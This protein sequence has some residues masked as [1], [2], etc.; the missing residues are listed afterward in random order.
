MSLAGYFSTMARNNAWSNYRLL[1]ACAL[2]TQAE[3]EAR[4]TSFFPSLKQTLNHILTVDWYYLDALEGAG[5]GLA[6]FDD[7]TPC[8]SVAELRAAQAESDRRLIRF[9]DA[10]TDDQLA[11]EIVL[12]RPGDLR[13]AE[14]VDRTLAH[15]FVHETHHRGQA[16]AM[17]AGTSVVPP[18]L[19][20]FLLAS[21]ASLRAADLGEL[22][23]DEGDI[24][25]PERLGCNVPFRP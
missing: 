19:D 12:V 3:F 21:D 8:A 5:R 10:S 1:A 6:V 15:L 23:F 24:W 2:L 25:P 9:C 16:H 11:G 4:R 17:L 14:R 20:E 7:E 13:L 18:Q 22:G